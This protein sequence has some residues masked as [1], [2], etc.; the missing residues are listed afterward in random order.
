MKALILV[1]GLGTRL[2]SVIQDIPKPMAPIGGRPFLEYQIRWLIKYGFTDIVLCVGYL[3]DYINNYFGDGSR[4]GIKIEY[5]YEKKLLG[6]AGAIKNAERF[7][8]KGE[9]FLV[10]NGDSYAK[11]NFNKLLEFHN[12]KK[13]RFTIGITK[14]KEM[15]RYGGV[16]INNEGK[17][18]SF[19]EKA[20]KGEYINGGVYLFE[21]K[22]LDY[23]PKN[24]KVSLETEIFPILVKKC[25]LNSHVWDGYFID[26]GVPESYSQ[27]QQDILESIIVKEGCSVKDTMIN[28]DNSGLG[29][30]LIVDEKRKLKGLIT[31]GDIRRFIIK[32][33]DLN[34]KIQDVM[35]KN[36]VTAKVGWPKE[37]IRSLINPR[38]R[39]IPLVDDKGIV[40]DIVLYTDL[41]EESKEVSIVRAKA[42]LRVSFAGGGTDIDQYFRSYGGYVLNTTIDKYCHGTLIK[43][44]DSRICIKSFDFDAEENIEHISEIQ[45]D[46]KLDLIKAVIKL[47]NP[48]FG[49]DLYL[50]SDVPPGSGLGSSAAIAAVVAGLLNHLKEERLDD[51]QLA[52][53]IYKA[54]REE[55]KID[56]GWQ[57]Q[58]ATIF[59]GFNFIEFQKEEIVVH[60]LRVQ[61]EILSELN[62]NLF[63]CYT[64]KTRVSGDII[65]NQKK[66][67]VNKKEDVMMALARLKEITLSI[68]GALLRGKMEEFGN[69]LHEAWENKKRLDA[70]IS[71]SYINK[72]Y[73]IAIKNGA[74]GGKILGAGGGG[75]MLFFCPVLKKNDVTKKLESAGGKI[76]DFNFD[77]KGLISWSV[78]R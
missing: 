18:I 38:I 60:P 42:P 8:P 39:H 22:L 58:Y 41:R 65:K 2:R 19:A 25:E 31:D 47:L 36:P 32:E 21:P 48:A 14:S 59:G 51:Y 71:D 56:G 73:D 45:Y 28:M 54:E 50:H 78:R 66:S 11:I 57:D 26:I 69:L 17:V 77:T 20:G 13:S 12:N 55:I 23:I 30:A 44:N 35:I 33:D 67:Y 68:K 9:H 40:R 4:L 76:L 34:R 46:G 15:T 10:L 29:I 52:D 16:E 24:K 43:R 37:R 63:L 64:G 5:S 74:L 75:Y 49:F 70:K 72:L 3:G 6:T 53:L 61:E 7:I 62:S 27:L 1:G